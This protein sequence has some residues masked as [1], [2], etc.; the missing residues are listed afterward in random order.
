MPG[1]GCSGGDYTRGV[2][3]DIITLAPCTARLN[4]HYDTS[5]HSLCLDKL[6]IESKNFHNNTNYLLCLSKNM[7][8]KK[9]I[10]FIGYNKNNIISFYIK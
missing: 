4:L 5:T 2:K 6:F 10:F 1:W 8:K 9:R 3:L 7:T